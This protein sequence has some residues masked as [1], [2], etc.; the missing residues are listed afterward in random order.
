[1]FSYAKQ[2]GGGL[3]SIALADAIEGL[4]DAHALYRFQNGFNERGLGFWRIIGSHRRLLL[5]DL[6][7]NLKESGPVI[8]AQKF[9]VFRRFF[10]A[11]SMAYDFKNALKL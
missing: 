6:P 11:H 8:P 4:D 1:M 3:P 10:V 5:H 9:D 2:S 7:K